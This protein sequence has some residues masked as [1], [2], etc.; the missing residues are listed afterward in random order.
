MKI[1]DFK[2]RE[3]A[4][5]I[6][7]GNEKIGAKRVML[8]GL[9]EKGKVTLDTIRK[10]VSVVAKKAVDMKAKTLSVALHNALD[11]QFDLAEVGQIYA[12]GIYYGSYR[13]DEF[14]TE[15]DD[16]RLG[17]LKVE[18]VDSDSDKLK[19]LNKGLNTGAYYRSGSKLCREQSRTGPAI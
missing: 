13:Y 19:N 6:I 18:L 7:Y 17:S 8:I 1:G 14:I 10:A 5:T 2:A 9:G 15:N 11:K 16:G 4:C 3:R 12:E